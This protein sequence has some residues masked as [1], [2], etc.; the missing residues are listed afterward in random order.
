MKQ[1]LILLTLVASHLS[2]FAGDVI[3]I[4]SGSPNDRYT[5][6]SY[7]TLLYTL[8]GGLWVKTN[9]APSQGWQEIVSD[10]GAVGAF[11]YT[12]LTTNSES[13]ALTLIT[14]ISASKSLGT[15]QP[16]S[17]ITFTTNDN[18]V[19][20]AASSGVSYDT[21][22][23]TTNALGVTV[24]NHF[25]DIITADT[26]LTSLARYVEVDANAQIITLPV[27]GVTNGHAIHFTCTIA[28]STPAVIT[29][30]IGNI[31]APGAISE[32]FISMETTGGAGVGS[33]TLV[34]RGTNWIAFGYT[35]SPP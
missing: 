17:N 31:M 35:L 2:L 30:T 29:N 34:K 24:T 3:S 8:A 22:Y 28:T 15:Y 25:P 4:A 21:N 1:F 13:A 6:G 12:S 32:T 23:F 14:N 20:I 11:Q 16:G 26:T 18:V 27:S 9:D 10:R 19:T 33:V 7:N 5:S